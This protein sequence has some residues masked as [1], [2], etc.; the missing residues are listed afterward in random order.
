[1]EY[2]ELLDLVFRTA[3]DSAKRGPGY[4]QQNSVLWDVAQRVP[5]SRNPSVQQ[6]I[7]TCWHDLFRLGRLSW[8]YDIDNPDAPF[9]H[10]PT[11]SPDRER[12]MKEVLAAR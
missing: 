2:N 7:L 4:A 12:V 5:N 11:G 6:D 10:V 8:G 9:F 1:M 3:V